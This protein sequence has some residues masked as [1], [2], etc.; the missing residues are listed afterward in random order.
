VFGGA[1]G[2]LLA[3]AL[4]Q[5]CYKDGFDTDMRSDRLIT[6]YQS[7]NEAVFDVND[8]VSLSRNI[9]LVRHDHDSNP[10]AV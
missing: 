10:L 3:I 2:D 7:D 9:W 1:I 4:K 8:S 5:R 6:E